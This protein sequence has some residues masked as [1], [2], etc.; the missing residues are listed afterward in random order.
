MKFK[1]FSHMIERR[2]ETKI[3]VMR[4]DNAKDFLNHEFHDFCVKTGII[5]DSLV[6]IL[7][8]K[9]GLPK[10]ELGLFKRELEHY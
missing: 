2:F 5:H 9:M 1:H 3:K 4:T 8:N 7:R 10:G 6:H